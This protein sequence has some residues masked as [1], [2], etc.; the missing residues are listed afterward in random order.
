[1]V[2][3]VKTK[4]SKCLTDISVDIEKFDNSL[5]ILVQDMTDT[6]NANGICV[7]LAA[8]QLGF[9]KNVIVIKDGKSFKPIINPKILWTSSK[10]SIMNE[11]C[12][13]YPDIYKE[14]ERPEEI[15][16]EYNTILGNKKILK[17]RGWIARI[18]QHEIDHLMGRC[19]VGE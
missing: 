6:I 2:K 15:Q 7:G 3:K 4:G 1:M 9:N 8:P 11:G 16:I 10:T 19:Q 17:T 13:S 18:I 12:L 5:K 14:I